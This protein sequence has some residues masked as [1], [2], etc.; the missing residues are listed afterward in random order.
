MA[1]SRQFISLAEAQAAVF[2]GRRRG[3]HEHQDWR[4]RRPG[5]AAGLDQHSHR[6][7]EG[8][9]SR[10]IDRMRSEA[11]R[12]TIAEAG[13]DWQAIARVGLG[14]PGTMDIAE[15]ILLEPGNLPRL[16]E[17]SDSRSR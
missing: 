2:R 15:G 13:L 4:G 14:T 11:L 5:P 3:R 10:R 8:P 17:L 7:G 16:V 12:Q 9:A 6:G 1:H